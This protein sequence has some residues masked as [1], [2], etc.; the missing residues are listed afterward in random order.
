MLRPATLSE[1]DRRR[2][3]HR[4]AV[5]HRAAFAAAGHRRTGRG[6]P[7]GQPAPR[8]AW[9]A[10]A[11]SAALLWADALD[12]DIG[13]ARNRQLGAATAALELTDLGG[14]GRATARPHTTRDPGDRHHGA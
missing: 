13:R 4:S 3:A 11:L 8:R 14:A 2:S 12:A 10:A 6:L 5:R 7:P 9:P 1:N